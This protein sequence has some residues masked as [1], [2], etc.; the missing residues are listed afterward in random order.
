[1]KQQRISIKLVSDESS[2]ATDGTAGASDQNR[3]EMKETPAILDVGKVAN[4][5]R[6]TNRR[7]TPAAMR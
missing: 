2:W 7:K 3:Q 1:M 6:Q 4:K 5:L